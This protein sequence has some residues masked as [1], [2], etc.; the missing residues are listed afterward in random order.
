MTQTEARQ[1]A[2]QLN[3]LG[4]DAIADTIGGGYEPRERWAVLR[5]ADGRI[6]T[7]AVELGEL[8]EA[9]RRR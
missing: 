2:R 8:V 1:L 4:V 9:L 6:F 5:L 7:D 3:D